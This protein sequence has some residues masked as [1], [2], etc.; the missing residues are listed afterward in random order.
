MGRGPLKPFH[1]LERDDASVSGMQTKEAVH[2]MNNRSA[3]DAAYPDPTPAR[4]CAGHDGPPVLPPESCS[5]PSGFDIGHS[6]VRVASGVVDFLSQDCLSVP[7]S[8]TRTS[9]AV[10]PRDLGREA[11]TAALNTPSRLV[12]QRGLR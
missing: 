2:K 8:A 1:A 5:V 6:V 12:K 7:F 11:R 3:G 9:L 10:G 4:P